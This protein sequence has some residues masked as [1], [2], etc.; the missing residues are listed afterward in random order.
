LGFGLAVDNE[1][2]IY[3]NGKTTSDGLATS[4]S[5]QTQRGGNDDA[6]VAKFNTDD[7]NLMWCTYLGGTGNDQYRAFV[8]DDNNDMYLVGYTESATAI[9][10]ADA[11]QPVYAGDGDGMI[12]KWTPDGEVIWST[13]YGA[14]GQDRYH[15]ITTDL[16]GNIYV[17]GTTSSTDSVVTAGSYQTTYG[18]G[19]ADLWLNKF[20]SEGQLI[21]STL[22]GGELH[23]RGRGV[24]TDSLGNIY[25]AGFTNST[26]AIASPGAHQE[27]WSDGYDPQTN[28]PLD[29]DFLFS[30]S[31]DGTTRYWG[32]YYGGHRK[33]EM[34][35]MNIDRKQ[36]ALYVVGSTYSE[37]LIAFGNAWQSQISSGSD[38]IFARWNYDGSIV[39]GSYFGNKGG[40]QFEDVEVDD[41]SDIYLVG[42]TESDHLPVTYG[43]Y[44]LDSN[45]GAYDGVLYKFY[46]G[47]ACRDIHEPNDEFNTASQIFSRT[48][49][50]S[51]IY[52]Y[53][54]N[55][56]ESFDKDYFKV[57]VED[58]FNNLFIDL[59]NLSHN[60]DLKAYNSSMQLIDESTNTGL[61]PDTI[62]FNNMPSGDYYLE[63]IAASP[64]EYDTMKCY[65]LNL[66]KFPTTVTSV[67]ELNLLPL[68]L[69]P[70]PALGECYLDLNS[71]KNEIAIVKI[72]DMAGRL[73]K[74]ETIKLTPGNQTIQVSLKN[75]ESGIYKVIVISP[76]ESRVRLITVQ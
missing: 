20:T 32:T 64:E 22:Y 23:D 34:W 61:T 70:N 8:F 25:V 75:L 19:D 68:N 58:S 74:N 15:G 1:D 57:S 35:G 37:T 10:T 54:G 6:L 55:L 7:G 69:Y 9:A 65:H 29:D 24:E 38:A 13:Y 73:Q 47:V 14:S 46:G 39:Y 11:Y 16:E 30:I 71:N 50:D 33:D 31:N 51:L 26:T 42:K 3:F 67:N 60:Y 41:N 76:E 49:T 48:T 12:T 4:G 66:V 2:N 17:V 52:G 45:G 40:E 5:H 21:W 18:G 36:K 56:I 53:D 62:L 63:V 27:T 72:L 28:E 44:Q 59:T 43:V